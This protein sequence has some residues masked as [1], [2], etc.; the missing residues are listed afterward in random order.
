[1]IWK[2]YY[3]LL[4]ASEIVCR[5][6]GWPERHLWLVGVWWYT[7]GPQ[8]LSGQMENRLTS[9]WGE[10]AWS[11]SRSCFAKRAVRKSRPA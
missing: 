11:W 3:M 4:D 6:L 7:S 1:M 5:H 8:G 9:S 2:E 10:R